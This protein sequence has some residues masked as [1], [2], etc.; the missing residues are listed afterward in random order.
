MLLIT[1]LKKLKT[2]LISLVMKLQ[3]DIYSDIRFHTLQ[4]QERVKTILP[5]NMEVKA[6]V[7]MIY[8][9]E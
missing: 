2:F 6:H 5:I 8:G 4:N 9:V 1:L 7:Y 3:K